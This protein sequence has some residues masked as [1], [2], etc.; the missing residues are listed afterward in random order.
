MNPTTVPESAKR[1]HPNHQL[2]DMGPPRGVSDTDCGTAQMLLGDVRAM[3]G[4]D[5]RDQLAFFKPTAADLA[6]LNAG[7]YL[8]LNQ[9]G[10]VVQPFSLG[11]WAADDT[12][13]SSK[14][15]SDG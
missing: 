4:F 6:T 3:P 14:E 2:V 5:G 1:A 13:T 7:G 10:H 15:K 12:T 9:L 8:V 11:V